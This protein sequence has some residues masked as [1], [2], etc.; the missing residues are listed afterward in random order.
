M[1]YI[2]KDTQVF[3]HFL[4]PFLNALFYNSVSMYIH[5]IAYRHFSVSFFVQVTATGQEVVASSCT[6]EVQVGYEE[7]FLLR[8]RCEA[9]EQAAQE[10]GAVTIPEG[11]QEKG[12]CGTEEH[13]QWWG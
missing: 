2:V 5:N 13:A 6:G 1:P 4:W 3:V 9:L 8:K 7:K 11:I 10:G 12:V